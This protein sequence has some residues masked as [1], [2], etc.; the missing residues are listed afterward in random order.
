MKKWMTMGL[1]LIA[2]TSTFAQP[3]KR[4][5]MSKDEM[6]AKKVSFI[7]NEL[8]LNT[9]EAQRFWPVYNEYQAEIELIRKEQMDN[10]KLM[11]DARRTGT[12]LSDTQ[13]EKMMTTRFANQS[14]LLEI[15]KRY[16]ERF[17][18]VLPLEKV[19]RFYA[20]EERFKL[21]MLREMR[22]RPHPPGKK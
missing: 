10:M 6:Q 19:A 5:N 21:E 4:H 2:I 9:E 17:K 14:K 18:K 22:D 11:V 7:A 1:T 16:Y 15:E 13:I 8:E 20:A 12:A 3:D